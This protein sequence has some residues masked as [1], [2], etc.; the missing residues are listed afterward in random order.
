MMIETEVEITI[1]VPV[2]ISF[3]PATPDR[4]NGHPDSWEPGDPG[5][6]EVSLDP[7]AAPKQIILDALR[8]QEESIWS[9]VEDEM[10]V[11]I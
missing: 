11:S 2:E 9:Q 10:E 8:D 5:E 3:S 1:R 7:C 6:F 4:L